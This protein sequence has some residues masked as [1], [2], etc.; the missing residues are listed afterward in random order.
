MNSKGVEKEKVHGRTL[1][2]CEIMGSMAIHFCNSRKQ[3]VKKQEQF[4]K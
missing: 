2:G 3:H 1:K 4:S